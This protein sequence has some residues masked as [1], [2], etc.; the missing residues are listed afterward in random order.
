MFG[1]RF[2]FLFSSFLSFFFSCTTIHSD[3][4]FIS[5]VIQILLKLCC[6]SFVLFWYILSLFF[7]KNRFKCCV[8]SATL[9]SSCLAIIGIS[10]AITLIKYCHNNNDDDLACCCT[11]KQTK[12]LLPNKLIPNTKYSCSKNV[13]CAH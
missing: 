3:F 1:F 11:E 13:L 12:L 8:F 9:V 6:F 5:F 4:L 2:C 10:I 7:G